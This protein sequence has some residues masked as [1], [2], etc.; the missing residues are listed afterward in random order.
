MS[1]YT[2]QNFQEFKVKLGLDYSSVGLFAKLLN[3]PLLLTKRTP[4]VLLNPEAHAALVEAV[5]ALSPHHHAVLGVTRVQSLGFR[6]A[7]K[8]SVHYL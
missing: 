6:L 7:T 8:A 1:H 4:V 2:I 5:I 3:G